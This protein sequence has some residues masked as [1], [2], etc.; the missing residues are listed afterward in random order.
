MKEY[1]RPEV[2]EVGDA[3]EVVRGVKNIQQTDNDGSGSGWY[4]RATVVDVD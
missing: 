1:S 3:A 4:P 2:A